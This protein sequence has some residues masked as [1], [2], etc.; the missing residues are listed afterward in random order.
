M[1]LCLAGEVVP[2]D[3][4]IIRPVARFG[5][6]GAVCP[7]ALLGPCSSC[8]Y[9]HAM[10]RPD[11]LTH[12]LYFRRKLLWGFGGGALPSTDLF[13]APLEFLKRVAA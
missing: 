11:F 4:S 7:G 5:E 8:I 10:E 6:L 12:S 1:R 3:Q 9:P 2:F 13:D